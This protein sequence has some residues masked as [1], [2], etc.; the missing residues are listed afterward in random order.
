MKQK[1]FT[2]IAIGCLLAGLVGV[3]VMFSEELGSGSGTSYPSGLDTDNTI[4]TPD[5]YAREDVINDA[6]AAIVAMQNELGTSPSGIYSDLKT[7]LLSLVVSTRTAVITGIN[8]NDS[9]GTINGTLTAVSSATFKN[10]IAL[11]GNIEGPVTSIS[12]L[13]VTGLR[14]GNPATSANDGIKIFNASSKSNITNTGSGWN[15]EIECDGNME[16]ESLNADVTVTP[17]L[18]FRV[19]GAGMNVTPPAHFASSVTIASDIEISGGANSIVFENESNQKNT[20]GW[21]SDVMSH[22]AFQGYVWN[23]DGTGDD[24]TFNDG[25]MIIAG[26]VVMNSSLTV[27]SNTLFTGNSDI[28]GSLTVGSATIQGGLLVSTHTTLGTNTSPRGLFVYDIDHHNTVD[29]I[30]L[31]NNAAT[32]TAQTALLMRCYDQ[33]AR[34]KVFRTGN[35]PGVD[36]AFDLYDGAGAYQERVRITEGG[37]VGIGNTAPGAKLAVT[38]PISGSAIISSGTVHATGN[39]T[40][41]GSMSSLGV[42]YSSG[43][44]KMLARYSGAPQQIPGDEY[45]QVVYSSEVFDTSNSFTVASSS[46]VVPASGYYQMSATTRYVTPIVTGT[47][48]YINLRKNG[49]IV[50]QDVRSANASDSFVQL[51]QSILIYCD[52]GDR[53]DVATF[54]MDYVDAYL[55]TDA[56]DNWFSVYWVP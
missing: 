8:F 28:D 9:M 50:A 45:T 40:S 55:T 29:M 31:R 1:I 41:Q 18:Q 38:G 35:N 49:T 21:S 54:H 10:T 34:I 4:E 30:T 14:I 17:V 12:S 26:T 46:F 43:S 5:D 22:E 51:S 19:G 23:A 42:I 37:N 32:L 39:I 16:I 44:A 13:T 27:K 2:A 3:R 15:M 47:E 52:A 48:Y 36:M 6:Y 24:Y 11:Q 53:L 33:N 7:R 56:I 20:I 25:R